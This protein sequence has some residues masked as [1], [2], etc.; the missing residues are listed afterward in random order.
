MAQEQE[1]TLIFKDL[2]SGNYEET[3]CHN[4]DE[5]STDDKNDSFVDDNYTISAEELNDARNKENM[6]WPINEP[7]LLLNDTAILSHGGD[8]HLKDSQIF[9]GI[10]SLVI[11]AIIGIVV[12][13]LKGDRANPPKRRRSQLLESCPTAEISGEL[14]APSSSPNPLY[15]ILCSIQCALDKQQLS[16]REI[17]ELCDS[18]TEQSKSNFLDIG[19]YDRVVMKIHEVQVQLFSEHTSKGRSLGLDFE[20]ECCGF[21]FRLL[22]CKQKVAAALIAVK[23]TEGRWKEQQEV[24]RLEA[25]IARLQGETGEVNQ[26]PF[27]IAIIKYMTYLEAAAL[28]ESPGYELARQKLQQLRDQ[29]DARDRDSLSGALTC[30]SMASYQVRWTSS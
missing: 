16:I 2:D 29:E 23:R 17:E 9:I 10:S 20:I 3:D 19:H 12:K 13:N 6:A 24:A 5:V 28:T 14:L 4:E 18:M 22:E 26:I 27:K 30:S 1:Y 25:D 15:S 21:R 11:I 8:F 7:T